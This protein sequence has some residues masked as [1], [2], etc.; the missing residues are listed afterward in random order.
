MITY[1]VDSA[2]LLNTHCFTS[3]RPKSDSSSE[4]VETQHSAPTRQYCSQA[5][6]LGLKKGGTSTKAALMCSCIV[7]RA[8]V[9]GR[10]PITADQF[11]R[12][13][14]E[15]LRQNPYQDC[16]ALDGWGKRGAIGVLFR[17]ELK[18]YGYTF[19]GK[20]TLSDNLEHLQHEC[21][22]YA[23]LDTLRGYVVPVHLGLVQLDKGYVLPGGKRAVHM[24]FMYW[25]GETAADA[26]IETADLKAQWHRSSRDVWAVGVDHRDERDANLLWN[27]ERHRV[28]LIDFDR[29][30]PG[31]FLNI[32]NSLRHPGRRGNV[33]MIRVIL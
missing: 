20:G 8:E 13:V 17:L 16:S 24:M 11:T 19:V 6:L 32:G 9:V 26:G 3:A 1:M 14:G 29:A 25:G 18:P 27:A 33:W 4:V 12:L 2:N 5:C 31:R 21:R 10:H 22:V 28:M 15:R 7:T 23:R 30:V